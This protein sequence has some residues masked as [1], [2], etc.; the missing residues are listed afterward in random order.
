MDRLKLD[1]I[2]EG[3]IEEQAAPDATVRTIGLIVAKE[4]QRTVI[5]NGNLTITANA[6]GNPRVDMIEW[7]GNALSVLAGTPAATPA[8]PSPTAG[9]IPIAAILVPDSFTNVQAFNTL[10]DTEALFI[11]Y[12][13]AIGGL[14]AKKRSGTDVTATGSTQTDL[15]NVG[16]PLYFPSAGY[17]YRFESQAVLQN[18]SL[19]AKSTLNMN[20]RFDGAG[21]A[22]DRA[23]VTLTARDSGLSELQQITHDSIGEPG[24]IAVGAH[25]VVPMVQ[26]AGNNVTVRDYRMS[27]MQIR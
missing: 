15:D 24:S 9:S 14:F 7:N 23:E 16:L 11:A 2:L 10:T 4:G 19:V 22:N 18:V 26:N 21:Q 8:S 13:H 1:G 20:H 25:R 5:T 6:S 27:V 3:T 12:Y 17:G